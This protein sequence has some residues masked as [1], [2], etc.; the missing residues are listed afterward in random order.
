MNKYRIQHKIKTLAQLSFSKPEWTEIE[1]DWYKIKNRWF[2]IQQ[3]PFWNAW[4]I[5]KNIEAW[6]YIEALNIFRRSFNIIAQR[7]CFISQCYFEFL[8]ESRLI[9]KLNNNP[10]KIFILHDIRDRVPVWLYFTEKELK[11]FKIIEKELIDNPCFMYL[12]ASN[13][14][15]WYHAKLSLLCS[16]LEAL[17]GKEEK[18]S[19]EWIYT[20]YNKDIMKII[21]WD[22]YYNK[23]FGKNWLRHKIQHWDFINDFYWENYIEIIYKKILEYF[24]NRFSLNFDTNIISPQRHFYWNLEYVNLFLKPKSQEQKIDLKE[25]PKKIEENLGKQECPFINENMNSNWY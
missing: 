6:H 5:E 23:I 2:N 7:I 18:E 19:K 24:N 8:D 25:I 17:A 12:Q 20:T 3:W 21:L 22:N 10:E 11:D 14:T 4:I 1:I 15:L 13:N 16:A 9:E